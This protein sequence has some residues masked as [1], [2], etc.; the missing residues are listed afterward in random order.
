MF[1]CESGSERPSPLSA[2]VIFMSR[3]SPVLLVTVV[4]AL[5]MT[6]CSRKGDYV[7]SIPTP[8]GVVLAPDSPTLG[9]L[10]S[11]KPPEPDKSIVV[12]NGTKGNILE[13]MYFV[14]GRLVTPY[15]ASL[16][17]MERDGI[18]QVALFEVTEGPKRGAR[19]WVQAWFLRPAF[20]YL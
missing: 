8:D 9:A 14:G 19:G 16:N 1:Y 2:I 18:I 4:A 15:P 13:R 6:A 7:V 12:L 17:D 20:G 3:P 11:S 10:L 5:S